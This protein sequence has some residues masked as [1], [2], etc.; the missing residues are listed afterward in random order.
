[1]PEW[2]TERNRA[3]RGGTVRWFSISLVRAWR[4]QAKAAIGTLAVSW[5][6]LAVALFIPDLLLPFITAISLL[7]IYSSHLF[8]RFKF[9]A[10]AL[11]DA[12][13]NNDPR[14]RAPK[15][16]RPRRI[17]LILLFAMSWFY[18]IVFLSSLATIAIVGV[19]LPEL[20]WIGGVV[21][22]GLVFETERYLT[23]ERG[24]SITARGI[25]LGSELVTTYLPTSTRGRFKTQKYETV[26]TL[27]MAGLLGVTQPIH[28]LQ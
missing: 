20:S 28:E 1:M 10:M 13:F 7:I 26:A 15:E 22:A 6:G 3:I 16:S 25:S 5:P 11:F 19:V 23:R 14:A 18:F 9:D 24:V 17:Y 2:V 8:R 12:V 21:A 27:M 4:S